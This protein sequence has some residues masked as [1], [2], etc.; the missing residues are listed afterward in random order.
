MENWKYI[1]Y[2]TNTTRRYPW[3]VTVLN[4]YKQVKHYWERA[5]RT[6]LSGIAE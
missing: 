1:C 4:F 6:A 2:S 3:L 5:N